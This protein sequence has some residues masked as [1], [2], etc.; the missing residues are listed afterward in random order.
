MSNGKKIPDAPN[1]KNGGWIFN[2]NTSAKPNTNESRSQCSNCVLW[3]CL[4]VDFETYTAMNITKYMSTPSVY[5]TEE[6]K[7]NGMHAYV[8]HIKDIP[9]ESSS[10]GTFYETIKFTQA[11]MTNINKNTDETN[12]QD[13]FLKVIKNKLKEK[14]ATIKQLKVEKTQQQ[15][16]A[17]IDELEEFKDPD[18]SH[19]IT[20]K[21][22]D[23]D[24]SHEKQEE[25]YA[26]HFAQEQKPGD[27]PTEGQEEGVAGSQEVEEL[28][29]YIQLADPLVENASN[30]QLIENMT[31]RLEIANNNLKNVLTYYDSLVKN[32]NKLLKNKEEEQRSSNNKA[33]E[34]AILNGVGQ[35]LSDKL[36]G[37]SGQQLT[38]ESKEQW[39]ELVSGLID[40]HKTLIKNH[41]DT[42]RQVSTAGVDNLSNDE[43]DDENADNS[44]DSSNEDVDTDNVQQQQQQQKQV[45]EDEDMKKYQHELVLLNK[46]LEC[47]KGNNT[48]TEDDSSSSSNNI[49]SPEPG[50]TDCITILKDFKQQIDE[51]RTNLLNEIKACKDNDKEITEQL[52]K[53]QA[54]LDV[55]EE[56]LGNFFPENTTNI[57]ITS[58]NLHNVLSLPEQTTQE[59]TTETT[60][61]KTRRNRKQNKEYIKK[62]KLYKSELHKYNRLLQ[63]AGSILKELRTT[64]KGK[65][66]SRNVNK[67]VKKSNKNN[68]RNRSVMTKKRI[69][70]G[71]KNTNRNNNKNTS[72]SMKQH[73]N[74]NRSA[75][76]SKK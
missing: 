50:K 28:A 44:T 45:E 60:G 41:E 23:P 54:K 43:N 76:K 47:L 42:Y 1:E 40:T 52:R 20:A 72:K 11:D 33:D 6:L 57:P 36:A 10:V 53:L 65:G 17:S 58:A 31:K 67:N 3:L 9:I 37:Q 7:I 29:Q 51:H 55:M 32:R 49:N 12:K 73:K 8:P 16:E 14:N 35:S 15:E 64:S 74:K 27:T 24:N 30:I 75:K 62:N 25:T 19:D 56:T 13:E 61:G 4:S 59:Q 63:K 18:N 46:S 71:N 21:T 2:N 39:I 26:G 22:E 48:E 68:N 69:Y 5:E 70:Y 34:V 66:L 38:P